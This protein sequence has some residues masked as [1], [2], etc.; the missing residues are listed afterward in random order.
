MRKNSFIYS[1]FVLLLCIP[2]VAFSQIHTSELDVELGVDFEIV[3]NVEFDC[4]IGS[5]HN[6]DG[7]MLNSYFFEVGLGFELINDLDVSLAHKFRNNYTHQGY[8][9]D[10]KSSVKLQYKY[11]LKRLGFQFRNKFEM[12]KDMYIDNVSDLFFSYEDRNRIK[13]Y[14]ERKKW[15]WEP[16][17]SIETF[18]P[19]NYNTNYFAVSQIRYSCGVKIDLD[20]LKKFDFE[21]EYTLKQYLDKSIPE[22][23]SRFTVSFSKGF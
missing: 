18:H 15:E 23:C 6:T 9:L 3:K 13:I 8:F 14:Y 12:E 19:I 7:F 11:E 16:S 20:I 22:L 4:A 17:F 21:I 2:A 1:F 5:R 10:Q